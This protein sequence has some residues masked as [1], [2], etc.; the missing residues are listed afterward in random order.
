MQA[1][2]KLSTTPPL[3]G[4]VAVPALNDALQTIATDFSGD[5]D[6]A[7]YAWPYTKWADT[8][9][10]LLKRRNAAGT[11]WVTI[12]SIFSN[13][14]SGRLLQ[15]RTFTSAGTATYTPTAGTKWIRARLVGGGGGGAGAAATGAS[16]YSVGGGGGSGA[17]SEGLFTIAQIGAS[18]T[19]TIG[20]GGAGGNVG[21]GAPGG[22]SS[23]G[24]LM[25]A[26]GGF[27]GSFQVVTTTNAE[28]GRGLGGTAGAGGVFNFP[29][30]Q[31][32]YGSV[33]GT[34]GHGGEGAGSPMFGGAGG[35][36]ST[37]VNTGASGA[38]APGAGGGGATNT[39]GS[40]SFQG[41]AGMSGAL[42]ILEYA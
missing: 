19:V 29:G 38:S 27:A 14:D 24:S 30:N 1:N 6:P 16:Q 40:S 2:P 17:Y 33:I 36:N 41:G 12:G 5:T 3:P 8:S 37:S 22:T 20:V 11:D 13:Q 32:G 18:Q 10:G 28:F 25:T 21:N 31:G 26:P 39:P 9:T 15:I 4:V 7:A 35:G 42:E 23:L 34:N